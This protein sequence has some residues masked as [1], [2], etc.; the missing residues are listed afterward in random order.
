MNIL[1]RGEPHHFIP[2]SGKARIIPPSLRIAHR[3]SIQILELV[4]LAYGIHPKIMTGP[5][6]ERDHAWPRQV[7]MY[8]TRELTRRSY[9]SIGETYGGRD[10]STVFHACQAVRQRIED[11][12]FDRDDIETLR[13][14]LQG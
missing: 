3:P 2:H 7:A 10:H 1:I 14:V 12:S 8:L 6:R 4:A 11:N 5:S 13:Q 9:K